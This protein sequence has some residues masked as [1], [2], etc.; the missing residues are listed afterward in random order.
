[1]RL[2]IEHNGGSYIPLRAVHLVTGGF[3]KA[4][5]VPRLLG[6]PD[7]YCDA[8]QNAILSAFRFGERDDLKPIEYG[9]FACLAARNDRHP[10]ASDGEFL[11]DLPGGA[12]VPADT[13][14]AIFLHIRG[15]IAR[16]PEADSLNPMPIWNDAPQ[17]PEGVH[18]L[19]VEG[20][21]PEKFSDH[22]RANS[23]TFQLAE[24][25]RLV[26]KVARATASQGRLFNRSAMPG[27]KR[28]FVDAV[29]VACPRLARAPSTLEDHFHAIGLRWRQGARPLTQYWPGEALGS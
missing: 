10:R 18:D 24:L 22:R 16:G 2:I 4:A 15:A 1:M 26:E 14:K 3:F 21:R 9:H 6:V 28:Q 17:V 25:E 23:R 8:S 20:F 29:C 5:E 19:V 11:V 27:T 13:L 7:E 12:V